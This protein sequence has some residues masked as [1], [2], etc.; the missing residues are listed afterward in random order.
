MPL[1]YERIAKLS[2][3]ESRQTLTRRRTAFYALSV[4]VGN[5]PL[6]EAQ[7]A[8]VDP[9]R[10]LVALPSMATVLARPALWLTDPELGADYSRA[11]HGEERLSLHRPL[12]VE[13]ELIGLGAR[14][15]VCAD[16]AHV[17]V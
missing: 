1:A 4:G 11:L 10:E 3:R 15:C 17:A 7:L 2:V 6:D 13:G 12:P 14:R 9:N 16:G 8:F 5:D